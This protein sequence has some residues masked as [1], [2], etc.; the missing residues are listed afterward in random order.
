[1]SNFAAGAALGTVLVVLAGCGGSAPPPDNPVPV[2]SLPSAEAAKASSERTGAADSLPASEIDA[3]HVQDIA[4]YLQR[5]VAG[6]RVIRADNGDISLR[7]RGGDMMFRRE[8]DGSTT[9]ESAGE[10]LVVIDG[11]PV[12][13]GQVSGTLRALNPNDIDTVQVLKDVS[14]TSS[15]GMRGAHGVILITMKKHD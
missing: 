2:S 6:L 14:S 13:E 10:P 15:Y 11:M 7:I 4:E 12:S 1:M 3:G 8:S 5:H 9:A